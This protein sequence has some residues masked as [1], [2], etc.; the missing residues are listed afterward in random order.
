MDEP[1]RARAKTTMRH[2]PGVLVAGVPLEACVPLGNCARGDSAP[3]LGE[4]EQAMAAGR[5]PLIAVAC[6]S[7]RSELAVPPGAK[8]VSR[9]MRNSLS[10]RTMSERG[11]GRECCS[12]TNASG[13]GDPIV[14]SV[15]SPFRPLGERAPRPP[16]LLQSLEWETGGARAGGGLRRQ[17][18]LLLRWHPRRRAQ[19][20]RRRGGGTAALAAA[21]R[22]RGGS[23]ARGARL[24][25]RVA[26]AV[27]I[28][29]IEARKT[30]PAPLKVKI[31]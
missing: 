1:D 6:S 8:Q 14:C 30:R 27:N 25:A 28:P 17:L 23:S 13:P 7:R 3:L 4:Q 11:T 24:R 16:G 19:R 10:Q 26:T 29:A 12:S 21:G 5:R 18:P 31:S 22:G 9:T 20:C 2:S 15:T